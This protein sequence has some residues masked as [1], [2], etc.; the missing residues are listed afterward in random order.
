M[1]LI[2]TPGTFF[3]RANFYLQLSGML[4]AGLPIIQALEML[5]KNSPARHFRKPIEDTIRVLQGGS[6]FA[7]AL[8]HADWIQEFDLALIAAG[9]QSGRLDSNL[10]ILGNYYTDQAT[11]LRQ[12]FFSLIYPFFLIHIAL[13]VFPTSYLSGVW[14]AGGVDRFIIQKITVFSAV[15]AGLFFMA[16]IFNSPFGRPWR[17]LLGAMANAV[18]VLG[19]ARRSNA[20]ARF[21][22]ALESL[23]TAG[24]SIVDSW[25]MAAEA[26]SSA[27]IRNAV[28]W[29]IPQ[30]QS[31]MTPGE[32]IQQLSVF[33]DVFRSAYATGE[34]SGQLDTTLA[35]LH[36]MYS[37]EARVK[38]MNFG[39]A[40]P[41]VIVVIVLLAIGYQI[42][43]FWLNYYNNVN[44]IL[45]G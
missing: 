11:M 16:V 31:G 17:T 28:A 19:G 26:S 22:A 37:E 38:F 44:N 25:K 7:E 27:K 32:A 24:V 3:K 8:K 14:L 40:A 2:V 18:P 15:W 41:V 34:I 12:I 45:N 21:A 9:E 6:T 13:F 10:R 23:I 39:K 43:R 29:A 36:K 33:P 20:L 4:S 42:V 35:R 1:P 30:I 5:K